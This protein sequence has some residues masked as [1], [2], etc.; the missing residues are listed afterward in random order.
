[1]GNKIIFYEYTQQPPFWIARD[2]DGYWLVPA[3]NQGWEE[4]TP[5]IGRVG[6]LIEISHFGNINLG[7]PPQ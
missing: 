6:Y 3:K 4:R 2:E 7:I 5:F 1:M